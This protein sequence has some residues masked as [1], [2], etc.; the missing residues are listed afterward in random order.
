VA[1]RRKYERLPAV[2]VNPRTD[3]FLVIWEDTRASY[4]PPAGGGALIDLAM[5]IAHQEQGAISTDGCF[6][7]TAFPRVK[8][9]W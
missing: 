9:S 7:A 6:S 3:T 2:A 4:K 8:P 5:E 1:A